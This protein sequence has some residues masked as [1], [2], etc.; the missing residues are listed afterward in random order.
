MRTMGISSRWMELDAGKSDS[1][2]FHDSA[3]DDDE[4]PTVET[5]C[6]K[7]RARFEIG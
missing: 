1:G 6:G 2:T 7:L 3:H 4:S 5:F